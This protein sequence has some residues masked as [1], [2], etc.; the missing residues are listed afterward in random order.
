MQLGKNAWDCPIVSTEYPHWF[1]RYKTTSGIWKYVE[2]IDDNTFASSDDASKSF[3]E[4]LRSLFVSINSSSARN[5]GPIT[6]FPKEY[7]DFCDKNSTLYSDSRDAGIYYLMD[8]AAKYWASG[9]L[10]YIQREFN[11]VGDGYCGP[12]QK[13][14][15]ENNAITHIKIEISDDDSDGKVFISTKQTPFGVPLR[16]VK[17]TVA[18][19]YVDMTSTRNAANSARGKGGKLALTDPRS[20][21]PT[22][23]VRKNNQDSSS[24]GSNNKASQSTKSSESKV[25]SSSS[26]KPHYIYC[27][28]VPTSVQP[29]GAT[30][31]SAE[32][33]LDS[34]VKTLHNGVLGLTRTPGS[35]DDG[36]WISIA[37][38]DELTVW[39]QNSFMKFTLATGNFSVRWSASTQSISGFKLEL[40][41]KAALT[42]ETDGVASSFT[43]SE[44]ISSADGVS[45]TNVV[46]LGLNPKC[47]NFKISFSE[48]I[49]MAGF[50]TFDS[51]LLGSLGDMKLVLDPS[52]TGRRNA[53]W[54][55]PSVFYKTSM[56]LQFDLDG[57]DKTLSGFFSFI[58][59]DKISVEAK[60]AVLRTTATFT[61]GQGVLVRHQSEVFLRFEC[62]VKPSSSETCKFKATLAFS[63]DA[64]TI[65]MRAPKD[66]SSTA[67]AVVRSWLGKAQKDY[68]TDFDEWTKWLRSTDLKLRQLELVIDINK[69]TKK[70]GIKFFRVKVEMVLAKVAG[71]VPLIFLT[72]TWPDGKFG[73]L[74]GSFWPLSM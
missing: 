5:G 15:R 35:D 64:I 54:F 31:L 71:V 70:R 42:F 36:K 32:S 46:I 9:N 53:I 40:G 73:R 6:P 58:S 49:E 3:I 63:G 8:T 19:N 2:R 57:T 17:T 68:K 7:K 18:H 50:G 28:D 45:K 22:S 34:F 41:G 25:N 66:A 13:Q 61:V 12:T 23:M 44:G 39:F 59:S 69:Q 48:I 26:S 21:D 51:E 14:G 55:D 29:T 65:K 47:A 56:R 33:V 24:S 43:T 72:Y 62:T 38:D 10:S 4:Q 11:T 16:P 74:R 20:S 30:T 67:L 37:S 1:Q 27:T 60:Y 52:K